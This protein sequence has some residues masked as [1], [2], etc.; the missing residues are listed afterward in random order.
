MEQPVRSI[1]RG[2]AVKH[3][4]QNRERDVLPRLI[5]PMVFGFYW[6]LLGVFFVAI[7]IA[8]WGEVPIYVMGSGLLITTSK[9]VLK[10]GQN[11]LQALVF[12]PVLSNG[13]VPQLSQ[14]SPILLNTA[15]SQINGQIIR[16]DPGVVS[17]SVARKRYKLAGGEAL[18]ITLPSV[19]LHARITTPLLASLYVGSII[20]ASIQSG[21]RHVLSL[22]IPG[23]DGFMGGTQ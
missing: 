2:N 14:N 1:F 18:L 22:L 8:W 11:D 10:T 23:L 6:L 7:G 3:Y 13:T 17:P 16:I 12:V 19:V 4:M 5:S 21:S 20:Q 15:N 9:H